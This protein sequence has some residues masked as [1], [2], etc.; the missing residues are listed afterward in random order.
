MSTIDCPH[1][2]KAFE[3]DLKAGA[4]NNRADLSRLQQMH[5]VGKQIHDSAVSLGAT[6]TCEEAEVPEAE[7]QEDEAEEGKAVEGSD[8]QGGYLVSDES[9][10][11]L[12]TRRGGKLDPKLLGAAHAALTVGYRGNKYEGPDKEG[13]LARLKKL[14][15]EAGLDWPESKRGNELKAIS[16]TPTEYRV[17]N[18]IV[19]FGGRDLEGLGSNR[20][21]PDGTKGE[22]FSKTTDFESTYTQTGLLYVDWEHGQQD[23][24]QDEVLGYVDWKTARAD[25]KGLWV[26]RV[27][28]RRNKY[29]EWLKTLIDSGLIGTSSEPVQPRVAKA[30][31]GCITRW[32]LKRDTLTVSPMEPRM[33]SENTLEALKSLTCVPCIKNACLKNG[34]LAASSETELSIKAKLAYIKSVME[35]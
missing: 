24:N 9:G 8:T 2:A 23:L 16:E 5:D 11:H 35:D 6:C 17:G 34:I 33:L 12:P 31:N 7:T 3:I 30:A 20:T 27:L 10:N 19:L 22:Y 21:N 29:V 4:R 25:E 15:A 18:Y 26:E 14:Y 1:C 32:P 13:A 28:N